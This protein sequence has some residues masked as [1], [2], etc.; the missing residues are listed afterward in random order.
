MSEDAAKKVQKKL[1]FHVMFLVCCISLILFIDK[2]TLGVSS[3]LGLFEETGISLQEY[4]NLNMFFYVGYVLA[5][6]PGHYLL[7]RLPFGKTVSTIIFTWA[8]VI[9]LHCVATSYG[10]LIV[11][12][13]ALGAVE[14]V[15]IPAI[16]M[17]IGMFFNREEQ[18]FL[19]PVLWISTSVAPVATGFIS[20]GLLFSS[21]PVRPWK[22]F[23]VTTGSLT[24]ALSVWS[25]FCY[26]NN[27]A[28]ASFLTLEEKVHV[29]KRVQKS[30]QSSIEQKQFKKAQFIETLK[31]PV[32]WVFTLQAFTLMYA[33]NLT[34]GQQNLL[35]RSLGISV[36][37]STLVKAASGG[38]GVLVYITATIL[39]KAFP[40]NAAYHG[41]LWCLPGIAGGIGMVTI[42]WD[43]KLALL[44][45]L[46]LAGG[47]YGV[48]YIVALGWTSSSAAGYTK[49]LTR[50]VIFMVGYCAGNLVSPQIWVPSAKPR[51]YGAWIS[52]VAVSWM[53][54]PVVLFV[55]RWILI[56]RNKERRSWAAEK[57][58]SE[59]E[60]GDV[61]GESG[62][63][64]V[65]V[66][67]EGVVVRRKVRVE[68]LDLTDLEN[69]EFIYPL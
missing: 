37:G 14:A 46:I 66:E 2:A 25:W 43:R 16:E 36:L 28:E 24:F 35:T 44:A 42:E 60:D 31:D 17:T 47:T 65:D 11:V 49:K 38:F 61:E 64:T 8:V 41:L 56:R 27:P 19:Q 3:I 6:W 10:P 63:V 15:I 53:G 52:M 23:M 22:L 57:S 29:I 45:C 21:S 20:Y 48:T 40:G 7:Q 32:S 1:Y 12:R 51:Y 26:P 62:F 13:M 58:A 67:E 55:I 5:L 54:M 50:N 39:V 33:N 18:A 30:S 68:M 9:F 4:I 34:Y 69:K 59:G